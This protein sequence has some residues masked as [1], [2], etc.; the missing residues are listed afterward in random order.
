MS[1]KVVK[2]LTNGRRKI[3]IDSKKKIVT[4]CK[5]HLVNANKRNV[6]LT[7]PLN[8]LGKRKRANACQNKCSSCGRKSLLKNHSNFMKSGLPQRLLFSQDGQWVDFEK[9][10]VDLV[11]EDF[12]SK[13]ISI[14]VK[15]NGCHFILDILHMIQVDLKTGSQKPIAW[16]DET[17]HCVFP[18]PISGCHGNHEDDNGESSLTPEI[19]LH[20]EIELNGLNNNRDDEC[21][22]E[23][24]VK[25]V[26]VD[27]EGKR[28][29]FDST[30]VDEN[31]KS[32]ELA[33]PIFETNFGTVDLETTKNMF[34]EALGRDLKVD[35]LDVK[36]CS[37]GFMEARLEMFQKQVEITQKLRGSANVQYAWFAAANGAP[38]GV[39][40]YGPNGPKLGKYGFGVH[41]SAVK[42]ALNSATICDI[43]ENGLRHM[44]LCRVILGNTEL[45]HPGSKQFNPSDQHFDSGVDNLEDPSHYVIWNMNMNTHIIPECIV[46]FK[47]DSDIKGNVVTQESRHDMSR[48][49]TFHDLNGPTNQD[50]SSNKSGRNSP[51][52]E[53]VPSHGSS[54]PKEPKSP[55]MPFS[56]LFEAVSSKVAPHDMKLLHSYYESFRAK[57]MLREDFIR[58]LRSVVGDQLLR[59]AILVLQNKKIPNASNMYEVKEVQEG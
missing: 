13:R 33:S 50:S 30:P 12:R 24:N 40:F 16:I 58:K 49:T 18:D 36:K 51:Q 21:V 6:S 20:L 32:H 2:V 22:G 39:M 11:T 19:N 42:S 26:K 37:S 47:I 1:S 15:C 3:I 23:S 43:D 7:S 38:S 8:K 9:E 45:V 52:L 25:R 34:I 27:Q 29:H 53:A 54:T 46:S 5:A 56:M 44:V 4:Q 31:E 59:S 41:L 35:F 57:K 10:I 55:W 14:E 48:I 28:N 17:G